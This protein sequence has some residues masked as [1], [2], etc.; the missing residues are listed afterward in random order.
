MLGMNRRGGGGRKRG[1]KEMK[2]EEDDEEDEGEDGEGDCEKT[3]PGDVNPE[4]LK[5]FNVCTTPCS[6]C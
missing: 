5:A 4:R 3:M 6:T 1:I 2:E